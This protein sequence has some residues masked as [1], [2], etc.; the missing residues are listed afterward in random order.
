MRLV[1]PRDLH[2]V[3]YPCIHRC[4]RSY[5]VIRFDVMA[6]RLALASQPSGSAGVAVALDLDFDRS[7]R[8]RSWRASRRHETHRAAREARHSA[9]ADAKKVRMTATRS[10]LVATI[11]IAS[12]DLEAPDVVAE[13]RSGDQPCV[14]QI[15][16]I[17]VDGGPVEPELGEVLIDLSVAEGRGGSFEEPEHRDARRRSLETGLS[18]QRCVDDPR[19]RR[20]SPAPAPR[21]ALRHWPTLSSSRC[22]RK[23]LAGSIRCVPARRT[24]ESGAGV[25]VRLSG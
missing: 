21:S 18:K 24:S 25:A 3:P 2:R 8:N 7:R 23:R 6:R 5:V 17:P 14:R 15:D 1:G 13:V 4:F 16:E 20:R 10:M 12:S 22:A 9:A 19:P 11:F